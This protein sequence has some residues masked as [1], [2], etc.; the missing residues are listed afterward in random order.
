M[1][2]IL[3]PAEGGQPIPV[4]KPILLIGRHQDCDIPLSDNS[5]VSRRHCCIVQCGDRYLI[6]DLGSMNGIRV[7]GHRLV[8][9]EL[10]SGDEISVADVAFTF[11]IDVPANGSQATNSATNKDSSAATPKPL[12][13]SSKNPVVTSQIAPDHEQSDLSGALPVVVTEKP[14]RPPGKLGDSST[15]NIVRPEA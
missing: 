1:A 12:V 2:T 9:S 4:D 10:K 14:A 15:F 8:E 6:R 13:I 3:V 5:K 11:R 7:N